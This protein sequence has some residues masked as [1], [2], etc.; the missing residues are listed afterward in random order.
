MTN[1]APGDVAVLLIV[2]CEFVATTVRR[3]LSSCCTVMRAEELEV[4]AHGEMSMKPTVIIVDEDALHGAWQIEMGELRKR[5]PL[6][7]WVLMAPAA[8][9]EPP[10]VP[11]DLGMDRVVT[12]PFSVASLRGALLTCAG[13]S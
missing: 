8:A 12:K 2:P 6:A 7:A 1:E 13:H 9:D 5:Y 10:T 4:A 11:T 3:I